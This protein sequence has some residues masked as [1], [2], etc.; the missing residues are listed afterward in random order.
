MIPLAVLGVLVNGAAVLRLK[1]GEGLNSRVA[2]LHLMEDAL[3]W[4]AILAGAIVIHFTGYY[5]IDPILSLLI[6]GYILFNALKSLRDVY[7]LLVQRSPAEVQVPAIRQRLQE[8]PEVE[9]IHDL[10][11]WSLEG[12]HHIL[13]LHAQVRPTLSPAEQLAL[14]NKMR[15][16]IREY[17]EIHSTI[18]LEHFPD[19][20]GDHC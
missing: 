4:I 18:E 6:A 9:Q 10:H 13:S 8:L 7:Y 3:G 17:G 2:A 14:K 11:I 1:K 19:A 12:I 5:I 15:S 20:C 16:I